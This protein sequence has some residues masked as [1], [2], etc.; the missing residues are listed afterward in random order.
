MVNLE[1]LRANEE[2]LDLFF[3]KAT[4]DTGF[5]ARE[6]MGFNYDLDYQSKGGQ[7][8]INVGTGG[9]RDSGSQQE[10]ID[11]IDAEHEFSMC[12]EPRGTYKSCKAEALVVKHI[13][14]NPDFKVAYMMKSE[15]QAKKKSLAIRRQF[16]KNPIIR[17]LFSLE[18]GDHWTDR[19][20]TVSGATDYSNDNPTFQVGSRQKPLTGGHPNL[21][22]ID[23][24]WDFEVCKT[25]D[26]F[27]TTEM[28]I[29]MIAPL[30]VPGGRV[31]AFGTRYKPG[32]LSQYAEKK[33]WGMHVRGCGY[34]V[35]TNSDGDLDLK[36]EALYPHL[37]REFLLSQLRKGMGLE[38]FCSQY[39]NIFTSDLHNPIRREFFMKA[40]WQEP[41]RDL[42]TWILVDAATSRKKGSSY[43]AMAVVGI[44][45]TRNY[46][47]LDGFLGRQEPSKTVEMLFDLVVKWQD[48]VN[49]RG[50]TMEH[51]T[52]HEVFHSWIKQ[53]QVRRGLRLNI[54]EVP[55]GFG[56][57]SK[58]DRIKRMEPVLRSKRFH[59]VDTFPRMF[60]DGTRMRPLWDPS[61]YKDPSTGLSIPGGELVRQ[62]L[63]VDSSKVLDFADALA[64]LEHIYKKSQDWV[65]YYS[66]ASAPYVIRRP[67]TPS[68]RRERNAG[69]L[70]SG[71]RMGP[72]WM[73]RLGPAPSS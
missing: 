11:F 66:A 23:D 69:H 14:A 5:V 31:L 30:R 33:G 53:E 62:F 20:W 55:R 50:V 7:K 52:H 45:Q 39:L 9:V 68:W 2:Q 46:F 10:S 24:F 19:A 44:D 4:T 18:P 51:V 8:R 67:W 70:D 1:K 58:K 64:D 42:S 61:G 34:E 48:R 6:I 3:R 13:L 57:Q 36:G 49:F 71:H 63:E 47:L 26:Q 56:E 22:I 12:L 38:T 29:E 17:D 21:I 73:D 40:N 41:M 15:P 60:N 59:I 37:T 54:R 25:A 43:T 16:E 72:D 65:C 28:A 32:D 35:F 27:A